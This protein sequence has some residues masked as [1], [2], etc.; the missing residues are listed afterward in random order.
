MT[1]SEIDYRAVFAATPS[2]YPVLRPDLLIADANEAYCQVTGRRRADLLG[3]YLFEA[4]PDDSVDIRVVAEQHLRASLDRVLGERRPDAMAVQRYDIPVPGRTGVF[5]ER[6]WS[7]VN[8][9]VLG[10]GGEVAWIIHRVEDVTAFMRSRP[11]GQGTAALNEW[12]ATEAEL[13]ARPGTAA[14]E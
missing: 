12:E 11:D 1:A 3:R 7:P 6:W 2:P 9:P 5:E 14:A 4:I 13:Y 10:P 8:T